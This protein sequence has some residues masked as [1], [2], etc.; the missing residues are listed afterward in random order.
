MFPSNDLEVEIPLST[1]DAK[2]V[3][4]TAG[5]DGLRIRWEWKAYQLPRLDTKN[6]TIA[7]WVEAAIAV[8]EW[9]HEFVMTVEELP[10]VVGR[11]LKGI[12]NPQSKNRKNVYLALKDVLERGFRSLAHDA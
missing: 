10:W 4:G 11:R 3:N 7:A 9:H 6:A 8:L 1:E 12:E 5:R 2:A